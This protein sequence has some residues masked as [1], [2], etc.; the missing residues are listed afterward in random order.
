MFPPLKLSVPNKWVAQSF[1]VQK[2][3]RSFSETKDA[4]FEKQEV[5]A[6]YASH[7]D[8]RKWHDR[9]ITQGL[10]FGA[11]GYNFMGGGYAAANKRGR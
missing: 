11:K 8:R 7:L 10:F 6:T 4:D 9:R 2:L 1:A 5:C 3:C